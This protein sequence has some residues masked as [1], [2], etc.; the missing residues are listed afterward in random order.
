[1][2]KETVSGA[3]YHMADAHLPN[4]RELNISGSWV[5]A[6]DMRDVLDASWI[7]KLTNFSA[8]RSYEALGGGLSFAHLTVDQVERVRRAMMEGPRALAELHN[9]GGYWTERVNKAQIKEARRRLD[10]LLRKLDRDE[11]IAE[12]LESSE[13]SATLAEH[14]LKAS[15]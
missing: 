8:H 7:G 11:G 14:A 2:Y 9:E 10:R 6:S 3:W 13:L 15:W 1:M 12:M 5:T 4:L